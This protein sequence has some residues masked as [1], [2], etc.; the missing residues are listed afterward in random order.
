MCSGSMKLPMN[1]LGPALLLPL[2]GLLARPA[3]L[4]AFVPAPSQGMGEGT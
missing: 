4:Q 2:V 1:P 3:P